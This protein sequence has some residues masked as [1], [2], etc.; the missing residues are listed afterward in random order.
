M[1]ASRLRVVCLVQDSPPLIHFVNRVADKFDVALVVVETPIAR[2]RRLP[3]SW[4]D[5][6]EALWRRR[7]HRRGSGRRELDYQ[8]WFGDTWRAFKCPR[9]LETDSINA[10]AV[11]DAIREVGADVA[12]DHGTSLLRPDIV[13]AVPLILNLH[14]GLSP[15]YRGVSC[16]EWALARWDPY[17]IG[18]SIHR[19]SQRIDGGDLVVQRR[20]EVAADDTVHSI[21]CQLTALGTG[22]MLDSLSV[23]S[24]S[25]GLKFHEQDL[26]LGF[27][28]LS[29]HNSIWLA[30][31]VAWLEDRGMIERMLARPSRPGVG[32]II[33][34]I[35]V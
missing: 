21:N 12:V 28:S 3:T 26:T 30:R 15:H 22:L 7:R 32:P 16:T 6:R 24:A 19:I 1:P 23:L 11:V 35:Q 25:G 20:A 4:V 33:D 2:P 5:L 17:S 9:I 10:P 18:V 29:K 13:S 8:R 31:H 14:W 27:L 34:S